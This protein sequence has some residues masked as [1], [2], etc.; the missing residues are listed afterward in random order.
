MVSIPVHGDD[1]GATQLECALAVW[2]N[3][4]SFD[5]FTGGKHAL[6]ISGRHKGQEKPPDHGLPSAAEDAMMGAA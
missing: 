1:A 4:V 5:C 2:L 6:Q 3:S